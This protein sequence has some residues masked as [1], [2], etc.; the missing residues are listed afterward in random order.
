M[1]TKYQQKFILFAQLSRQIQEIVNNMFI[2]S[3][4]FRG[5]GSW[6]VWMRGELEG[7]FCYGLIWMTLVF[8]V[9]G[10]VWFYLDNCESIELQR[11]ASTSLKQ[12]LIV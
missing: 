9:F 6:G 2:S 3:G 8:R 11:D 4:Y 7:L 1:M 12:V 5:L 10:C